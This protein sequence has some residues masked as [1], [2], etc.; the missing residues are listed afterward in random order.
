MLFITHYFA[1]DSGAASNR[2]T[3][4]AT[5]LQ[6]RGH[7]ITVL[8]TI[9]HYPTG[10]VPKRYRNRFSVVEELSGMRVIHVW[11]WTTRSS[12][13]LLRL[14]SQLSFMVTCVIHGLF[15]QQVDVIFIENQPIFTGFAGWIISKF[16]RRPY[17]LNVSDYWPE[18]LLVADITKETSL[19]YRVFKTLAN[20]TQRA[21]AEIVI[22]WP[23]LQEGIQKRLGTPPPISL[24]YNAVDLNALHPN[25]DG[26]TFRETYQLGKKRL[27]TFLGVLGNHID[28]DTMLEATR[29]LN[30]DDVQFLFVGTGT[31]KEKLIATLQ[32][33]YFSHCR[34]IE[35]IDSDEVPAFWGASHIHFWAVHDNELDK[36]RIQAKLYEALASGTPT[37]IAVE[38]AMSELLNPQQAGITV[39]P[40]DSD[41]LIREIER[42]LD[43]EAHYQ[44]I[45]QNARQFADEQFDMEKAVTGYEQ[46]LQRICE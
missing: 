9:P 37:V 34:H 32:Q 14:I 6:S 16:K 5:S 8:T 41:T 39:S 23:G 20:I 27:I 19:A 35:W 4:L 43:D 30:R 42:L 26:D 24:I 45:S 28:L 11:L 21:A 3:R 29:R 7:E 13:I 46:I 22:L 36:L 15:V 25:T 12:K 31:Q 18:Y 44:H 38:G 17:V 33:S 10:I 2:L 40:Y 1:P